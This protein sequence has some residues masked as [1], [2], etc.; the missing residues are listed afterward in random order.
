MKKGHKIAIFIFV[1]VVLAVVL[2]DPAM[3]VNFSPSVSKLQKQLDVSL[4][5][6]CKPNAWSCDE[7]DR[8]LRDRRCQVTQ[9]VPCGVGEICAGG[10]CEQ[11]TQC[12]P[13]TCETLGDYQCGSYDDGCN[14][15]LDCGT[16]EGNEICTSGIC[17]PII[18]TNCGNGQIDIGEDCDGF[19]ITVQSCSSFN[20]TGSGAV[21][22]YSSGHVQ[23][24]LYDVSQ[25][26]GIGPFFRM[27]PNPG[28]VLEPVRLI[29]H[30]QNGSYYL[31]QGPGSTLG[32]VS[33]PANLPNG[34]YTPKIIGAP[35]AHKIKLTI[36]TSTGLKSLTRI[37]TVIPQGPCASCIR[38]SSLGTTKY[39]YVPGENV[40]L[41]VSSILENYGMSNVSGNLSL[42][43]QKN[44]SG[45]WADIPG[46]LQTVSITV[47]T[48]T[49]LSLNSKLTG[50][51]AVYSK[52]TYRLFVEFSNADHILNKSSSGFLI[53]SPQCSLTV[54]QNTVLSADIYNCRGYQ[55]IN[56]V[57]N[58]TV[59]D[60]DNHVIDVEPAGIHESTAPAGIKISGY[61]IT[62]KNCIVQHAGYGISTSL[63]SLNSATVINNQVI[64]GTIY[65]IR[66]NNNNL[67]Q[68]NFVRMLPGNLLL[69]TPGIGITADSTNIIQNNTLE[70]ARIAVGNSN[71]VFNNT[72]YGSLSEDIYMIVRT[73]KIY[74]GGTNNLVV[75]NTLR[76]GRAIGQTGILTNANQNTIE[77][78][79]FSDLYRGILIT[80]TY[81]S[82]GGPFGNGESDLNII[83][84]NVFSESEI[85]IDFDSEYNTALGDADRNTIEDNLFF[86]NAFGIK[87]VCPFNN[88]PNTVVGN[89]FEGNGVHAFVGGNCSHVWNSTNEGNSWD[90]YSGSGSYQID[91]NNIDWY[92]TQ[93]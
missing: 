36:L 83:R 70:N 57:G 40:S 38:F 61:G 73:S 13:E 77:N 23:E 62:V 90:D 27:V 67:V 11:D 68:N 66:L 20:F 47:P 4:A 79:F 29:A 65:G 88:G 26:S 44:V 12:E 5:E 6:Y 9:R 28:S 46:S 91:S 50:W 48:N 19:N 1:V 82:N 39:V 42:R 89:Q 63:G 33:N 7:N 43:V 80:P 8:V 45:Q 51:P 14:G 2:Y 69:Y 17:E 32:L 37:L 55:V 76:D 16:C 53:S 86:E 60:C 22:C 64:D 71:Q 41:N 49:N 87:L 92:P 54:A 25:C 93:L 34:T 24:C 72:L 85:G 74:L 31:W 52:E 15:T 59:L 56:I 78:N 21:G 18:Q 35:G 30:Q 10:V 84:G 75:G 3:N 81:S 58:S